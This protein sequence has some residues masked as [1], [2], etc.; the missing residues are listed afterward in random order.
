[1][2]DWLEEAGKVLRFGLL[3]YVSHRYAEPAVSALEDVVHNNVVVP[4][5][6]AVGITPKSPVKTEK[7]YTSAFLTEL[8]NINVAALDKQVPDWRKQVASGKSVQILVNGKDYV[9]GYGEANSRSMGYRLTQ[10]RGQIETTLGSYYVTVSP[11]G[12]LIT[13]TYDWN[14][15]SR[16]GVYGTARRVMGRMGTNEKAPDNEKIKIKIKRSIPKPKKK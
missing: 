5:Q 8:D 7:D 13:D 3:G 9:S 16:D 15:Q 1:M 12:M 14:R 4:V 10:P 6:K 11:Q 2:A